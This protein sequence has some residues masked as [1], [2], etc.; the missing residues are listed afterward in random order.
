MSI[1]PSGTNFNKRIK[2][3]KFSFEKNA[4]IYSAIEV[5]IPDHKKKKKK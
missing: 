3:Q 4:C 5:L 2:T 1:Q